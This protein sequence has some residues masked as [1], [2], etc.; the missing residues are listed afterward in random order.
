[1]QHPALWQRDFT[2]EGFRWL[3]A[4]D[5]TA[6]V[7][8]FNRVGDEDTVTCVANL[9]PVP[10]PGYRIGL[11][12]DGPWHEL[13]STDDERFGGSGTRNAEIVVEDTPW[14]GQPWSALITLPPLGMVFL[15]R[16]A[17]AG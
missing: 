13:L 3:D 6:S 1:M 14:Q 8:A 16:E 10:R 2:P 17:S 4:S 7:L 5:R 11:V 12:D 15:G 9:T